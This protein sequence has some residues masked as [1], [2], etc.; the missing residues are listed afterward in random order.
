MRSAIERDEVLA[1]NLEFHRHDG[2]CGSARNSFARFIVTRNRADLG[3]LED[4]GVELHSRLGVVVEPEKWSDLLH[5]VIALHQW[6]ERV[7]A[8]RTTTLYFF[9]GTM[10]RCIHG[11]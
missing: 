1:F 7:R 9:R 3:F 6:D 11:E 4:R 8:L 5:I 10:P 2:S